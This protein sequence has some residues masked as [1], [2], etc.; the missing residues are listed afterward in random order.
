MSLPVR[1]PAST[2]T[3]KPISSLGKRDPDRREWK[4]GKGR[5]GNGKMGNRNA[6]GKNG[7]GKLGNLAIVYVQLSSN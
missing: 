2:S 3:S 7:N 1:H 4:K 6:V 5:K